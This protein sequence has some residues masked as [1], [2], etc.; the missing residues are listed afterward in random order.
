MTNVTCRSCLA[1]AELIHP[2]PDLLD[3]WVDKLPTLLAQEFGEPDEE[4]LQL[5]QHGDC[6]RLDAQVSVVRPVRRKYDV[7]TCLLLPSMKI[8]SCDT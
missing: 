8:V 2:L 5:L 4:G 6:I 7:W 1:V 3:M